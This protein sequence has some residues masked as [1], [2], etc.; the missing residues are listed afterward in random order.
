[1]HQRRHAG[2]VLRR[3]SGVRRQLRRFTAKVTAIGVLP[4]EGLALLCGVYIAS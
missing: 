3:S 4:V 1:M 2:H